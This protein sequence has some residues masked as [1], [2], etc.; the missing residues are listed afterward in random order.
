MLNI[1]VALFKVQ[2]N[3]RDRAPLQGKCHGVLS[4]LFLWPVTLNDSFIAL[5]G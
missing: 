5:G 3:L 1:G 4:V 2:Q